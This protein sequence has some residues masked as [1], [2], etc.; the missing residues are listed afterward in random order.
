M[1]LEMVRGG[2]GGGGDGEKGWEGLGQEG[3]GG[4]GGQIVSFPD[5]RSSGNQSPKAS[6]ML[7]SHLTQ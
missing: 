7:Q 3:G 5:L 4:G 1:I 2:G 6:L